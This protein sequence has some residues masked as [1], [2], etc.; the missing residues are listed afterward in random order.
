MCV[1]SIL[2]AVNSGF[3]QFEIV[4]SAH[5]GLVDFIFTSLPVMVFI[6]MDLEFE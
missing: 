5:K 3:S 4:T 1:P 2:L 6:F